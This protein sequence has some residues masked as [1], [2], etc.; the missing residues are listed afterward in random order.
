M[1]AIKYNAVLARALDFEGGKFGMSRA[2]MSEALSCVCLAL[3]NAQGGNG[4]DGAFVVMDFIAATA[5]RAR[6]RLGKRTVKSPP[7]RDTITPEVAKKAVRRVMKGRGYPIDQHG[8][9][10][11]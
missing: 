8:E 6:K 7:K 11:G 10:E 5:E 4:N 2:Q 9:D 1:A 3:D